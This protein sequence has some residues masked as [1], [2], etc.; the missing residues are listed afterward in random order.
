M[1][2]LGDQ[3]QLRPA[4][5]SDIPFI[6]DCILNGVLTDT[7]FGDQCRTS[8]FKKHFIPYVDR[9]LEHSRSLVAC[10]A[11][12]PNTILA[13]LVYNQ[14]HAHYCFTKEAF[15]TMGIMKELFSESGLLK[16]TPIQYCFRMKSLSEYLKDNKKFSHLPLKLT[17]E[18][19]S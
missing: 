16:H 5:P 2:Q 19:T 14:G 11:D 9:L 8:V 10:Y 6:Y 1:T 17:I 3:L 4:I 18:L 15:R 7:Y 13:F 12:S